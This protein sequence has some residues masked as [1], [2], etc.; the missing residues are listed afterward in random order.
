VDDSVTL[1]LM[2][3]VVF[4]AGVATGAT[5]LGFAQITAPALALILDARLAVLLLAVTVPVISG[6][7]VIH[8]RRAALPTRRLVPVLIG[9]LVGVPVGI[10]LLTVLSS[11][12]IAGAVGA[13][14]L[15]YVLTRVTRYRPTVRPEQE[16]L[17]GPI[18]GLGGGIL[19]G[20]IGL[21]GPV[22]IP[23]LLALRLPLATFGYA[24]SVMYATMTLFRLFGLV[25]SGALVAGTMALG[26]GLL[27]PGLIG[28][29]VGFVLQ[30][31]L[32]SETF[33]RLVLVSLLVGAIALVGRAL[34]L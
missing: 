31:R 33:E 13:T 5:A 22:L 21:S 14:S 23:Y 28:Q 25:V 29:R 12:V 9:G 4:I 6:L 17:I 20:A 18:A 30:R 2:A 1:L 11:A 15:A 24:I 32:R 3:T 16:L 10:Y 34:G 26:V 7:Q 19:N 8:H 27:V